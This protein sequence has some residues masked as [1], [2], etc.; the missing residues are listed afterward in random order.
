[1]SLLEQELMA[2]QE[3]D[4]AA[5]AALAQKEGLPEVGELPGD[6]SSDPPAE[7]EPGAPD[8]KPEGD[9]STQE[10]DP[11]PKEDEGTAP[12][13]PFEDLRQLDESQVKEKLAEA[14][15]AEARR[16]NKY[17]DLAEAETQMEAAFTAKHKAVLVDPTHMAIVDA[18]YKLALSKGKSVAD[19]LAYAEEMAVQRGVPLKGVKGSPQAPDLESQTHRQGPAG[20]GT[21][22][23]ERSSGRRREETVNDLDTLAHQNPVEAEREFGKWDPET[24]ERWLKGE[25]DTQ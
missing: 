1:M 2:K 6:S 18:L 9:E 15:P 14:N 22:A 25:L 7:G 16:I 10:G 24:R 5:A 4:D 11:Q 21:T 19:A 23:Q 8:A 13:D 3:S 12:S 20:V 17:L